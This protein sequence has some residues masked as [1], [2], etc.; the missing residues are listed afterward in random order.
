M[1][2]SSRPLDN[3]ESFAS[4]RGH[5]NQ[6]S[7]SD[8]SHHVT[9]AIGTLYDDSDDDSLHEPRR[10]SRPLSFMASP[11]GGEQIQ[12]AQYTRLQPQVQTPHQPYERNQ[13]RI[14]EDTLLSTKST[15]APNSGSSGKLAQTPPAR[16]PSQKSALSYEASL[17]PL[18]P[19]SPL[20]P[21]LSLRDVQADTHSTSQF[22]I[23]NIDNPDD[24]AQELSNLQALRRMSI[25]VGNTA[26][27]DLMP[28]QGL[29]LMAMPSI[30]PTGEDDEGDIS[31]LL[32][33]PAKVH[34]ELAP[35]QF[36]N[37]LENRVQSMR[38]RSGES[39]LSID[40]TQMNN[41]GLM[42]KRSM[43]SRQVDSDVAKPGTGRGGQDDDDPTNPASRSRGS[44]ASVSFGTPELSLNE[45]VKDPTKVVQKLA[46]DTQR[47]TEAS[48]ERSGL[49]DDKPILPV[50]SMG[51][52]RSTR[53]T[54]RK[55]GSLRSGNRQPLS[56]R[57]AV[58][59]TEKDDDK[60]ADGIAS[61]S[62]EIPIPGVLQ[63]V[64]SEP[65]HTEGSS[66]PSLFTRR[67]LSF[68]QEHVVATVP[69]VD[70][71]PSESTSTDIPLSA[72]LDE[73]T[74]DSTSPN[75]L[76]PSISAAESVSH[77]SPPNRPHG[78]SSAESS[79][80]SPQRSS[81]QAIN[82]PPLSQPSTAIQNQQT[83]ADEQQHQPPPRSSRRPS[84]GRA[85]SHQPPP[86]AAAT[87]DLTIASPIAASKLTPTPQESV[88]RSTPAPAAASTRTDNLA[89]SPTT[90][91]DE[92]KPDKRAKDREESEGSK[93]TGWKWFKNDD[94]D[95]KKKEKDDLLK[96][97]RAKS[98]GE[99]IQ[100]DK[101]H[102]NARLDVL[103]SS[104]DNGNHK[105]RESVVLDRDNGDNKSRDE[106]KKESSRK[107]SEARKEKDGFSFGS[108]FG[109]SRRKENREGGSSKSKQRAASPEPPVI[110]LRP[111][112]DYPFTR[113]PI[114]E[115]RAIYRM[116]H[117]K[118]ANP[119]RDLRSQVLLSNFMYSY[120]AKV[121]AMHPQ[122][123]VPV[124]PQQ[125]RQEEER[126]R[127]EQE[128]QQQKYMEQQMQIQQ[129]QSQ[130]GT[131]EYN[132][133][134]HGEAIQYGDLSHHQEGERVDYVD[135]AQKFD[136]AQ[137]DHQ[138]HDSFV[139]GE[140]SK[141]LE[142]SEGYE[143]EGQNSGAR[144]YYDYGHSDDS[145]HDDGGMW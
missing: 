70:F 105:G 131:E 83:G 113:F 111:D 78:S 91:V 35:D 123:N 145:Q 69:E 14:S 125:K 104:I 75:T 18:Q 61:G 6:L 7:I 43:L 20:S 10:N 16:A 49:D 62:T 95:K 98:I 57:G 84:G 11:Y 1:M 33:V 85:N 8:P 31:R 114:V 76:G 41:T 28:F 133:E 102:D 29:S 109:G 26:D 53:T 118:L 79:Q 130:S 142:R 48:L 135:N 128:E 21:T 88:Q 141:Q 37:F 99:R 116:A 56:K 46:M 9:E 59:Q 32:W 137:G 55:G 63:R 108:I 103:Q 100:T 136:H 27:P 34:P 138:N 13:Q 134:Y 115:E 54:Y 68:T 107:S 15:A 52:R 80:Q 72:L 74:A 82:I 50:P 81:S 119:R 42:R 17:T 22:P 120:L 143:N 23:T 117:I 51:L 30:A 77:T 65:I 132:L 38:R 122:L 45:L 58:R 25:D 40:A 4:R 71:S 5:S 3:G 90:P 92:R 12:K 144:G 36:K 96:K 39:S 110:L 2:T 139:V 121:Q 24:I 64:L 86:A 124:S 101:S 112:V 126:K 93:S 47:Q 60:E 89:S 94:R 97:A 127:R 140:A 87:A 66:R 44:S 129:H 19:L 73:T 67:K 106:K